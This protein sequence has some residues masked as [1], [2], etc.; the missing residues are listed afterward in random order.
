M[1]S[2]VRGKVPGGLARAVDTVGKLPIGYAL[3]TAQSRLSQLSDLEVAGTFL[4]KPVEGLSS[5]LV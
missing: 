5:F 2:Q 1:K 3:T 4:A